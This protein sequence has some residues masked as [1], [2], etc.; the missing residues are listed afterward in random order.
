MKKLLLLL[1]ALLF[2]ISCFSS[3]TA[4]GGS[5]S[6]IVGNVEDDSTTVRAL[7][8]PVVN[9]KIFIFSI[10]YEA[11]TS[12]PYASYEPHAHTDSSGNF[13]LDSVKIGTYFIEANNNKGEAV[14]KKIT[15]STNDDRYNAG[16]LLVK[17]VSSLA[18]TVNT[19][20]PINESFTYTVYILGTRIYSK[21]DNTKLTLTF[22]DIPYGTYT[23]R[24]KF[25]YK[26][27]DY[28]ID[29]PNVTFLPALVQS[30]S[31]DFFN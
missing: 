29:K 14:T 6:E 17:K 8:W 12:M 10:T 25:N 1:L 13:K 5:G 22:G 3:G 11:N 26:G 31:V 24:F 21:G 30:L 4:D 2:L 15:I 27:Q 20:L 28:I 7:G 16:T 9:G 18:C 19:A 23:V